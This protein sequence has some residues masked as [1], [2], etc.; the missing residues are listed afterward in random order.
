MGDETGWMTASGR[1]SK[2]ELNTI[3]EKGKKILKM[4]YHRRLMQ[5]FNRDLPFDERGIAFGTVL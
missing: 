4:E 2:N 3:D 5:L 1:N